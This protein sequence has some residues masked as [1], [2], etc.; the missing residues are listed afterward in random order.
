[1]HKLAVFVPESHKEAVKQALFATGAGKMGDYEHCCWE[2]KG[3][4]Q[5]RPLATANPYLG[6][7]GQVESVIEFKIEMVVADDLVDAAILALRQS[8]PYEEPAFDL[9]PLVVGG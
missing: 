6:E 9:W 7:A 8:H 5:F 4:G 2:T 3:T 1:M